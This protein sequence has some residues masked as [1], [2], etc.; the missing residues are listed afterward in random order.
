MDVDIAKNTEID[1]HRGFKEP[2]TL[3][4]QIAQSRYYLNLYID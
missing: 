2:R 1:V 4:L 3:G